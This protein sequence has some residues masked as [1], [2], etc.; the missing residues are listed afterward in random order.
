M[1]SRIHLG[2]VRTPTHG[3]KTHGLQTPSDAPLTC[4]PAVLTRGY[5]L[6]S[7]F[8]LPNWRKEGGMQG[9]HGNSAHLRLLPASSRL[10]QEPSSSEKTRPTGKEKRFGSGLMVSVSRSLPTGT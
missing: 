10:R 2:L 7:Q 1:G 3:P 8:G 5:R 6:V 4:G 9:R